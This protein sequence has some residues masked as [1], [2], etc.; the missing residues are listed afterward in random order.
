LPAYV[1][2]NPHRAARTKEFC[3]RI[4]SGARPQLMVIQPEPGWE[5]NDCFFCVRERVR[6]DGGRIQL[7]WSIWEWPGVYIEAER[8]AVCAPADGSPW[9]DISPASVPEITARLFLPDDAVAEYDFANDGVREDNIHEALAADNR[10][11]DFFRLAEQ[12]NALLNSLPG[13]GEITLKGENAI[14]FQRLQR[15][16]LSLTFALA[17]EYTPPNARCFCGSGKKFKKCHGLNRSTT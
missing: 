14:H 4:R 16:Q 13:F 15:E 6:R 7:G 3:A 11:R 8:H 9:L 5:P 10:I 1:D 12:K 17:M 2:V